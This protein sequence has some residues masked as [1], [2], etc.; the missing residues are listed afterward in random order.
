VRVSRRRSLRDRWY[1]EVIR[2]R[3]VD[4]ACR[5]LL[6]L[7]AVRHMTAAGH[8][9]VPRAKLAEQLG[10]AEQRVTRRMSQAV[11]AGL[12]ARLGGGVNRQTQQYCA[13]L[14]PV[15]GVAERHPEVEVQGVAEAAPARVSRN[16]TL[17]PRFRVS[18]NDT[19]LEESRAPVRALSVPNAT[20]GTSAGDGAPPADRDRGTRRPRLAAATANAERDRQERIGD[21]LA[22]RSRLSTEVEQGNHRTRARM[23]G[24][25][26][27]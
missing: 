21:Y 24:R 26:I 3:L 8:V 6:S 23:N 15:Q 2:S 11:D 1:D 4:G 17:N 25:K 10:I 12:L 13:V 9:D 22:G 5:E 14:P 27:R 20:T 19:H 16:D 7:I 18:Q